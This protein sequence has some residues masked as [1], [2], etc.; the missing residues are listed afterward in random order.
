MQ[1]V[2][3]THQYRGY[4]TDGGVCRI[5][6]YVAEERPPLVVATELPENTNTSITNMAEYL[7]AEVMER[8]LTTNH[9][10]GHQPPF[11]WVEHYER[12]A[13]D[14]RMGLTESWSLV[15]FAHYRREQTRKYARPPGWRYRIGTPQWEPLPRER[16][17]ELVR[18]YGNSSPGTS[19]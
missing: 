6:V 13:A 15:T 11:L 18:R 9:L 10:L 2:E 8:Y 16:F 17:A 19:L 3:T 5:E 1:L 7:A 4:H 12:T 14:L